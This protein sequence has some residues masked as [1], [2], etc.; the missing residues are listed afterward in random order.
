[1]VQPIKPG[2]TIIGPGLSLQVHS[3]Y[4]SQEKWEK[5]RK[6]ERNQQTTKETS[7]LLTLQLPSDELGI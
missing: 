4:N 6:K 7:L 5:E 1:M 3:F 2:A